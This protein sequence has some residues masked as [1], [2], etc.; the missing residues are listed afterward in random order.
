MP[1]HELELDPE[2]LRGSI[3]ELAPQTRKGTL[4]KET[5]DTLPY[6]R[7]RRKNTGGI[8]FVPKISHKMTRGCDINP[9]T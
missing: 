4:F 2:L 5:F 3:Q 9:R 6:Q 8:D 1:I 7:G